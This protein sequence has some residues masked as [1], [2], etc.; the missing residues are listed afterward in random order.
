M[1]HLMN[2][3]AFE[4]GELGELG[5]LGKGCWDR[6]RGIFGSGHSIEKS[7]PYRTRPSLR[8]T[9]RDARLSHEVL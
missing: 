9:E 4:V 8:A 6:E 1:V 2:L 3:A 5:K 7:A